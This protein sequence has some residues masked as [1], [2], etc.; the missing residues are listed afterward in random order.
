MYYWSAW[1]FGWL[2]D[3]G[4]PRASSGWCYLLWPG[5]GFTASGFEYAWIRWAFSRAKNFHRQRTALYFPKIVSGRDNGPNVWSIFPQC[6]PAP[7][8]R[9]CPRNADI[10]QY[11]TRSDWRGIPSIWLHTSRQ[12]LMVSSPTNFCGRYCPNPRVHLISARS[13]TAK[14]Y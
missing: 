4:Y 11:P 5:W 3:I 7:I 2:C 9:L 6:R 14:K 8:R 12:R 10:G 1:W 13:W